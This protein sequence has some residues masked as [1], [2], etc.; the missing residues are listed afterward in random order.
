MD[1]NH[2]S[3]SEPLPLEQALLL[4]RQGFRVFPVAPLSKRPAIT[5]WQDHASRDEAAVRAMPWGPSSNIGIVTGVDPAH[6]EHGALVVV[7][8]D[9]TLGQDGVVNQ[10][11][12]D[13]ATACQALRGLCEVVGSKQA[14][15]LHTT[16]SDGYHLYIRVD[17]DV[18]GRTDLYGTKKSEG[19]ALDVKAK[20]GFIVAP[21]SRAPS[22]ADPN[23]IGSYKTTH[24][25]ELSLMGL[26]LFTVDELATLGVPIVARQ[27][28]TQS[29][30]AAQRS[31]TATNLSDLRDAL[32]YLIDKTPAE[33]RETYSWWEQNILL[34]LAGEAALASSE[35]T[36]RDLGALYEEAC[37]RAGG[38][39][40][41][42]SEQWIFAVRNAKEKI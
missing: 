25:A 32:F 14:M 22:K 26:P 12:F 8:L 13:E 35:D 23:V 9:N 40:A 31:G 39:T 11:P 4:A 42:N 19:W 21:G 1:S 17:A 37:D 5:G 16:A 33:E 41:N 36:E 28:Q 29:G 38:N 34:P 27:Q 2:F 10:L 15:R 24:G 20:G 6:P 30:R 18:S 7:D 3:V